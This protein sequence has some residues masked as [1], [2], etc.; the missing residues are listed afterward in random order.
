MP[1]AGSARWCK[2]RWGLSVGWANA[3][4]L[5]EGEIPAASPVRRSANPAHP[6]LS[7]LGL[8]AQVKDGM[9][10]YVEDCK[11]F[12]VGAGFAKNDLDL[13]RDGINDWM[14]DYENAECDGS[15]L[16]YCGSAGCTFQVFLSREPGKW[17]VAYDSPVRGH[18]YVAVSGKTV[19]RL[20]LHGS[21]CGRN[22]VAECSRD[23]DF[24]GRR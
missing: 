1:I 9:R 3:R 14:L 19:V 22:G 21:A 5:R 20:D 12:S 18:E 8:P 23:M 24:T 15:A 17:E 16:P 10:G 7:R 11:A 4:F 2:V 13:N 6:S